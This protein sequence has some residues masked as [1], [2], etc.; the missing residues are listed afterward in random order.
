M[1]KSVIE[2]EKILIKE[3]DIYTRI[4]EV[5]DTKGEAILD[6]NG[7]KLQKLVESQESLIGEIEKLESRRVA[8]IESYIKNNNLHDMGKDL[9][10]KEVVA[11]M[12][13]DSAQHL[14][15][16]GM[17]LKKKLLRLQE[18][19]QLN[20]KLLEDNMEFF[21]ILISGLRDSSSMKSGY[22]SDGKEE[23]TIT[24]PVL[25]NLRA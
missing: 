14:L 1:V 21:N 24:N 22:G 13:E 15:T 23:E 9:S 5:E 25:F 16:L 4:L 12:N 18:K 2:M 6:R 19:Q 8:C 11:S 7:E 10:L 20:M 17:D 3:N